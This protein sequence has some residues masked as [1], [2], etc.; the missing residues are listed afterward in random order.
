MKNN[1]EFTYTIEKHIA[2]IA[3]AGALT[4]ELN[5][6]RYC[7]SEAKYDLRRWRMVNGEKKLQK[8]ITLTRE[9]LGLLKDALNSMEE[10]A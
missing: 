7:G 5:V 8:G 6:I 10:L 9:E 2:T 3:S 4:T 1:K